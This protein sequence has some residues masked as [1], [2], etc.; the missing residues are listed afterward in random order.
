MKNFAKLLVVAAVLMIVGSLVAM[1]ASAAVSPNGDPKNLKPASENVIF[2]MDAPEGG[3]LPG[4]GSGTDA[5]NPWK[6]MEHEDFD[7]SADYPANDLNTAFYQ[8]TE[9]LKGTGGTIVICGPVHLTG[10][11]SYGGGTSQRDVRTAYFGSKVIKFTSV[12]NGV[13]YRETNGACLT[14]TAPAQISISG[15]TIWENIRIGAGGT[16]RVICF[17]H[18]TTLVGEGVECF[19]M[20]S[21]FEGVNSYYISLAAGKRYSKGVD[22]A[23]TLTVQSGTYNKIVAGTW[24]V[25]DQAVMDPA[26]TYLTIEGTTTVL[27]NIIGTTGKISP[28][29]GNVNITINGG[30]FE[31]DIV[32][33]GPTGMTNTDGTAKIAINGGNFESAWSISACDAAMVNNAP[34]ASI[35]DFS[36]WQG[37]LQQLAYAQYAA[38]EGGFTKT[39]FPAGV[40]EDQLAGMLTP[41][42]TTAPAE[43]ETDAPA[44]DDTPET[45]APAGNEGTDNEGGDKP[46]GAVDIGDNEGGMNIGIIIG[47][48]GAVIAVAAVVVV[49]V[50]VLSKNK[51][52]D[53]K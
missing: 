38:G 8:A 43:E 45:N 52:T 35:L 48:V 27:G 3:E 49:V 12:Y 37:D 42:E 5:N 7:P 1:S 30:T 26:T 40:T 9:E 28:F 44:G 31:C 47:I 25:S 15:S 46:S 19:P 24:G 29:G 21:A 33:V 51:K 11:Q 4:D 50:I 6:P 34:A 2:I 22:V 32:A 41:T 23:P 39:I 10:D 20:D 14:V 16:E 53:K 17:E 18:H 13:D 36:G